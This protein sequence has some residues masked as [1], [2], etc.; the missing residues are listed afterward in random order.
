VTPSLFDV[1][2][3]APNN[4]P[5]VCG[6]YANALICTV[7][8]PLPLCCT[9]SHLHTRRTRFSLSIS[10]HLPSV[11]SENTKKPNR[12]VNRSRDWRRL[13]ERA[14]NYSRSQICIRRMF[15]DLVFHRPT[16]GKTGS[17]LQLKKHCIIGCF[18]NGELCGAIR[19]RD[20]S[21]GFLRIR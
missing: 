20:L 21:A 3:V 17:R 10:F 12:E 7:T 15:D 11:S 1:L 18:R 14:T 4:A 5:R 19:T 9:A 8:P 13:R 6:K 2:N 16:Y